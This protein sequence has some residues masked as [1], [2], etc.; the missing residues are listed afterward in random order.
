MFATTLIFTL[1]STLLGSPLRGSS[2]A[3]AETTSP[4]PLVQKLGQ[5]LD[6]NLVW[7]KTGEEDDIVT[8]KKEVTGSDLL[9]FKGSGTIHASIERIAA[10]IFDTHRAPEW[11][12]NLEE[13]RLIQWISK[14]E[15]IEYDHIRTPPI[16]M[17]DREFVSHVKMQVDPKSKAMTF[18]YHSADDSVV[19]ATD[20]FIRGN[21]MNTTFVLTPNSDNTS[22]QVAGEIYCDPKGSVPKWLV[23]WVQAKWP[24]DTL[25]NLRRQ[26]AKTDIVI[27]DR[28]HNLFAYK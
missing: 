6:P 11:I 2:L 19:P 12:V 20:R 28:I 7:T 14:N 26:V 25:K 15:F 8:Y 22:T 18:H 4:Q 5:T 1:L 17:K 27:D 21:L 24:S 23:N 13:S 9:A 3:R 16:I 10:V